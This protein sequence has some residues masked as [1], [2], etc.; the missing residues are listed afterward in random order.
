MR[1]LAFRALCALALAVASGTAMAASAISVLGRDF[2]FPNKI[3]GLPEKLSDFKGLQINTFTTSDGVR[4]SYWEAGEGEPLV[5]VPGWSAN[6]AEYVN[7]MYLL[8]RHYHVYVLDVRNQGLSASVDY[9]ARIARFAADLKAFGDHLGLTQADYCGWSMGASVL[10]SYIDLFGTRGIRK[11]VFVDEPISIYSH[12]DWSEQERLD[13]GGMT[14]SPER[15]VAAFAG[16]PTNRLIVDAN[17]VERYLLRDSPHFANS[18]AFANTFIKNDP[19]AL[20]MVLFDHA[21]N[22]WRDVIRHKIDVPTA[23]FTGE[24]SNNL[25]SQRWMQKTI[26]GARLFVYTKAEQGDHFLM[27]KNPFKFTADLHA[28]LAEDMPRRARTRDEGTVQGGVAGRNAARPRSSTGPDAHA[29]GAYRLSGVQLRPSTYLGSAALELRMPSSAY[30][31]PA[32]EQLSDRNF[33]AW[34]PVDFRDGT[35]EVDVAS[36]LARDAPAYAR[37]F[38]G[39]S[40]RIDG[41]G[42]FESVYLRPTN[43][44]AD[45]QQRRN[46]SVQYVAYPDFRFNRLREEAPEKYETHADLA[47]G[48]WI[49][50]KLVVA[51]S[52]AR[53]YLDRKPEPALVVNDLKLGP[54]Q[55]GGVGIWLESGTI[56]HF[57]NLQIA[58]ANA[59]PSGKVPSDTA[60]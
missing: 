5:F 9:G 1:N 2:A 33:M 23:I 43:S 56:A 3:E 19:K 52:Q 22:D 60:R 15:M 57:R 46:H 51:G 45:D 13:A 41:Q 34:L 40:F 12:A 4:L 50:M 16:A 27:F 14:T 47:L 25:P 44:T 31:D 24:Y 29:V 36:D 18:E 26:S 37:G 58:P 7:V 55:Q 6:G 48:R 39:I 17:V 38:V 8:S 54:T 49:H 10:W 28:F 11:V 53:L 21:T 42:Q 30:Q 59:Y 20:A 32:R 35:I